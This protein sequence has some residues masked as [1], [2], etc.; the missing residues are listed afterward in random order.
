MGTTTGNRSNSTAATIFSG[1][2]PEELKPRRIGVPMDRER[3]EEADRIIFFSFF[4]SETF[5]QAQCFGFGVLS[6]NLV[7]PFPK[8]TR[9]WAQA[10]DIEKGA[11][12]VG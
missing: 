12:S 2:S 11:V 4:L 8:E 6:E 7:K 10:V 5:C 1:W 9:N 3:E